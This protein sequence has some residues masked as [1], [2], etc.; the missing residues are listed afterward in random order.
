M[1]KLCLVICM[2]A[3]QQHPYKVKQFTAALNI[4]KNSCNLKAQL[5]LQKAPCHSQDP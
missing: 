3:T 1:S 5:A 4:K 2:W